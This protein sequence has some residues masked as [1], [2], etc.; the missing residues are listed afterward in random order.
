MDAQPYTPPMEQKPRRWGRRIALGIL[1]FLVLS[2]GA[3]IVALRA[4]KPDPSK[5][6]AWSSDLDKALV[7]ARASGKLVLVKAG[8]E[9]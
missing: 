3:Y 9:W 1:G 5:L 2:T 7:E 6:G 8:S 4:F